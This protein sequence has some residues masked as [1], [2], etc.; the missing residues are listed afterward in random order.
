MAGEFVGNKRKLMSVG[1]NILM[2]ID[3]SSRNQE[4]DWALLKIL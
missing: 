1:Q 3:I 2:I 4:R